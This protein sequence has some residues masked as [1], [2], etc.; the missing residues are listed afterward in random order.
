MNRIVYL[1]GNTVD[2]RQDLLAKKMARSSHHSFLHLVPTRGRVME[3]ELDSRFWP[4][5]RVETLGRVIH[6][7]F[8]EH[9]RLERFEDYRP[10]NEAQRH[11]LIKKILERRGMQLDGLTYFSPLFSGSSGQ[12]SDF[13]GI[14]GSISKFFSLLVRNNFQ[15]SFV[16]SLGGKILR[17]EGEHPGTGE[18][19]YAL[20]SDL[21]WLFA[22]FEEIKR[23]IK[24]Y[25]DDDVL[26]SVS[27]YLKNGGEPDL[28]SDTGALV[29]DGFVHVSRVEEDILFYLCHQLRDIWWL[30]DYDSQAKD[31]IRE[32]KEAVGREARSTLNGRCTDRDEEAVRYEACRIFAPLVSLMD[33]LEGAGFESSINRANQETI[34]HPAAGLYLHGH[35]EKAPNEGLKV[36]SFAN[37]VDE[38]RAIAGEIKRMIHEKGL[39]ES[40]DLGRIRVIFPDLNDYSSLIAEVFRSHK[41]PFSLTKGL[42]LSSHPITQVF[43]YIF[44]IPLNH[45]KREDI[46]RLLSSPL[47]RKDAWSCLPSSGKL[48]RLR[49]DYFFAEETAAE[50]SHKDNGESPE[51]DLDVFLFDR[52]A[53]SCGLDRLGTN[54]SRLWEEGLLRVRDYYQGQFSLTK[55]REKRESI[56]SEYHRFLTQMDLLERGLT[57]FEDLSNQRHPQ[58]IVKVFFRILDLL[59]FPESIV[60]FPENGIGPE[61]AMMRMVIRRDIKAYT[62]LK[63]LVLTSANEVRLAKELFGIGS[64]D[65]LLSRFYD[66]F[67]SG[68]GRSYLMDTRNPNVV[69]VS[70][71]L[72]MR[73]RSFDYVFAGGLIADKFPLREP[74]DFILPEARNRMIRIRDPIDQSKHLFSHLLRNCRNRLYLSFPR[75]SNEREV[76]PSPMLSDLESVLPSRSAP[77]GRDRL[78]EVFLWE[79]NPYFVSEEELLDATCVKKR[80]LD[81][82][83]DEPFPLN[84]IISKDESL[85]NRLDRA[86]GVLRSRWAQ[87]GLFEYDGLVGTAKLFGEYSKDRSDYLSPSRLETLANCPMRYLFE[88]IYGLAILEEQGLEESSRDMGEHIHAILKGFYERLRHG[89]KNVADIGIDRAFSLAKE[90]AEEYLAARPFLNTLEFF[91]FQ[92]R[93][94]LAGLEQDRSGL[95]KGGKEREGVLAQLLRFEG[96]AFSDRLPGGVEYKFGQREDAPVRLGRTKIRGYVDRFDIARGDEKKTYIYDYKT[97]KMPTSDMVKKGLSFQLPAYIHALKSELQFKK[98]SACFYA[99]KRDV[100]FGENPLKQATNVHWDGAQGLDLSGIRLIDEYADS[101]M[102]LVEKGY[103]HHSAD[104]LKCRFCEYRYACY[105]NMRRMDHLIGSDRGHRI[106]SG[107]ENLKKWEKVDEF[108]K[109]WKGVSRSMEQA[110][111]LKTESGRRRHFDTVMEYRKWLRENGGSLPFYGEYIEELIRK[112]NEFE[113]AFLQT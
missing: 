59:G 61:P 74:V 106:Y 40:R 113:K 48:S 102:E 25:D 49:K 92:Y 105:R 31:P 89:E 79:E 94:F 80:G 91:E 99:L 5:E 110:F 112:I 10:I 23:E 30:L 27:D 68:L 56:L 14:Y 4:K 111:N 70:E 33:R 52:V 16:E 103:F 67:K 6:Q 45:F 101:L 107:K 54:F 93:E 77:E 29:L 39:D 13:S 8:E 55:N 26:S 11:L 82:M 43:H 100:F 104:G 73:G 60:Q 64:G 63:D 41:L 86:L 20:E 75:H 42:A 90:I 7:I 46:F 35:M 81:R 2:S 62:L 97:G 51:L 108:R 85:S 19:R 12:E 22:D 1:V 84:R 72:E 9:L 69:R 71:W 18:E 21:T 109:R 3:L 32:F 83:K 98:L 17:L 95:K 28:S 53:R 87:D 57:F 38:V 66:V 24:G 78:E 47:I 44:E 50:L 58:E 36:K 34:C 37:K 15:D 65:V 76:Q 96:T 88:H